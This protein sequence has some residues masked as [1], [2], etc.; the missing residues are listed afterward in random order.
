M[1]KAIALV[2]ELK[3]MTHK[4]QRWAGKVVC[5]CVCIYTNLCTHMEKLDNSILIKNFLQ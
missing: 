3:I 4:Q 2:Q 1:E 5:M